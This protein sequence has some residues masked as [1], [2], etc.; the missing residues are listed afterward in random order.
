MAFS[1]RSKKRSE[2]SSEGKSEE[3]GRGEEQGAGE[4]QEFSLDTLDLI[5][6]IG[7]GTFARVC[8]CKHKASRRYKGWHSLNERNV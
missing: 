4:V 3:E 6:T 7:T 5:K 1:R 2:T 8:L